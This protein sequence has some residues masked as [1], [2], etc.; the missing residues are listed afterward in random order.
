MII[1]SNTNTSNLSYICKE[2][3]HSSEEFDCISKLANKAIN[4][5]EHS[6]SKVSTEDFRLKISQTM[7]DELE[8]GTIPLYLSQLLAL[9]G[10]HSNDFDEIVSFT[11]KKWLRRAS[12]ERWD[13]DELEGDTLSYIQFLLDKLGMV[14]EIIPHHRRYETA[15]IMGALAP[16]MSLRLAYAIHLWNQG[17]RFNKLVFLAGDRPFIEEREQEAVKHPELY[18]LKVLDTDTKESFLPKTECEAIQQ[19]VKRTDFPESFKNVNLTFV[20]APMKVSANGTVSRPTNDDTFKKWLEQEPQAGSC[21]L[22]SN[23]PFVLA[24]HQAAL[25]NLPTAFTIDSCGEA[26]S[27]STKVS[28]QLDSLARTLYIQK[29]RRDQNMIASKL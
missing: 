27:E 28:V 21:L 7:Q 25:K 16:R 18:K 13:M 5:A 3:K 10:C 2:G 22:V 1:D 15:I 9:F 8:K 29:Q 6:S 23:Q 12:Q 20:R 19:I 11:Q 14:K 24:A 26:C 17:I 4:S